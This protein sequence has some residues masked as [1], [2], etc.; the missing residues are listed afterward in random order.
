MPLLQL[1]MRV[2]TLWQ[3]LCY[4]ALLLSP[5]LFLLGKKA[6][7]NLAT[8]TVAV[9]GAVKIARLRKNGVAKMCM[10]LVVV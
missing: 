9:V 6:P 2:I 3:R 7:L 10:T 1:L 5:K 4:L 8:A